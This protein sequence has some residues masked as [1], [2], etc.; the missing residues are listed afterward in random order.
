V[1]KQFVFHFFQENT[2]KNSKDFY[3]ETDVTVFI[4]N[5]SPCGFWA[6]K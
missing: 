5:I 6:R 4:K 3:P 1:E 2:A